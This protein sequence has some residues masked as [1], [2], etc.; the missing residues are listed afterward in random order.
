MIKAKFTK[1]DG[2]PGYLFGIDA[3]NVRRL[4]QGKPSSF[5]R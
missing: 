3:E 2:S 1:P 5:R 4:K